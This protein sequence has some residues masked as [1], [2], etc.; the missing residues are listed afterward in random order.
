MLW[1]LPRPQVQRFVKQGADDKPALLRHLDTAES[2]W[3][4][5]KNKQE[6]RIRSAAKRAIEAVRDGKAE[7]VVAQEMLESCTPT[8]SLQQGMVFE[9]EG[10]SFDVWLAETKQALFE[11]FFSRDL[12]C[13]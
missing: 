7:S 8:T 5:L 2:C 4:A 10:D 6:R 12:D 1:S 11:S 9:V 13:R 3:A